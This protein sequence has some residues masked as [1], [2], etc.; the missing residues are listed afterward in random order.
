MGVNVLMIMTTTI[1]IISCL[2]P[3]YIVF[4]VVLV[5]F[6]TLVTWF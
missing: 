6:L 2:P 1:T 5:I 3:G 4:H